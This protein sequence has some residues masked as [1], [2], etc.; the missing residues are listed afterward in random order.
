M[1]TS[2]VE[3]PGLG[4]SPGHR[5]VTAPMRG[6]LGGSNEVTHVMRSY[7]SWRTVLGGGVSNYVS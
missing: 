1:T 6:S 2:K 7:V 3:L 4:S 5:D